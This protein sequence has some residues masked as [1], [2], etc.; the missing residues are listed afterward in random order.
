MPRS[1]FLVGLALLAG[2]AAQ[3]QDWSHAQRV[4]ISLS[5]FKYAPKTIRLKAGVPVVLR[6]VNQAGGGH[7]FTARSFFEQAAVRGSDRAEVA[8][9]K[10][11]LEGGQSREVAL[12]PKAG[13]YPVKCTHSFHTMFGMTGSVVVE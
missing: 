5:S 11:D 4:E 6:F 10:I 7:D 3:A 13:R 9:G 2:P 1:M 12:V 8:D